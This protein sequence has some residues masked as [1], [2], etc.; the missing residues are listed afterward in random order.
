VFSSPSGGGPALTGSVSFYDGVTLLGSSPVV[1]NGNTDFALPN[2]VIQS[3]GSHN[4]TARYGGDAN[5]SPAI[6][7]FP[8]TTLVVNKAT[9]SGSVISTPG[10][11]VAVGTPLTHRDLYPPAG[12]TLTGTVNFFDGATQL[13]PPAW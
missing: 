2:S 13:N 12:G 11:P 9:P 6:A 5:Y 7:P 10:S 1:S 4:L 8:A 3:V